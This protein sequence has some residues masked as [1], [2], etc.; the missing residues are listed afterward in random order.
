MQ[1]PIRV[2]W[3]MNSNVN[4]ILAEVDQRAVT[5]FIAG[6]SGEGYTARMEHLTIEMGKTTVVDPDSI[7]RA[8][9]AESA[10]RDQEGFDELRRLFS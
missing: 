9:I 6:Q 10:V 3:L 4:R 8:R 7:A 5:N 1:M 2:F